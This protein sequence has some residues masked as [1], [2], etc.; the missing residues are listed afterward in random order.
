[1]GTGTRIV[2]PA[3]LPAGA[4]ED[5]TGVTT[6][7]GP[8][9]VDTWIDFLCP[10][11][12]RFEMTAGPMLDEMI[13]DGRITRVTHPVAFLDRASTTG[14][15]TRSAAA[16]ACAADAGEF[17]PYARALYDAQPPEGGPGLSDE[18]LVALGGPIGLGASFARCLTS[19]AHLDWPPYI[20]ATAIARGVQGT[21]TVFVAG[22]Q[23]PGDRRAILAAVTAASR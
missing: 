10:F 20:T 23:V 2:A 22:V 6:G 3:R 13:A 4:T 14:Y 17:Q 11:C 5:G 9:A 8:V 18:E 15:S 7:S 1:M 16:S 21:P 12:R 19:G